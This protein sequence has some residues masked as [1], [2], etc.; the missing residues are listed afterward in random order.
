[1]KF[2]DE[3]YKILFF[4]H[5]DQSLFYLL[6][7]TLTIMKGLLLIWK[8]DKNIYFSNDIRDLSPKDKNSP[9]KS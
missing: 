8:Y 7:L 1:M 2:F 3:P 6:G 5:G 4:S 9:V